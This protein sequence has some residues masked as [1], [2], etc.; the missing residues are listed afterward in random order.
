ML[1]MIRF[2]YRNLNNKSAEISSASHQY[3]LPERSRNKFGMTSGAFAFTLAEVLITL[4]IIGVVAALTIP[5]LMKNWQDLQYKTA[6]KRAYSLGLQALTNA[7]RDDL[8]IPVTGEDDSNCKLNFLAFMSQFKVG[9]KCIES[10]NEKC[11]NSVGDKYNNHPGSSYY[12]FIDASGNSWSM[13][14][15]KSSAFFVDTNNLAAPNRW[16]KDRFA[17]SGANAMGKN[18]DI[19]GGIPEKLI[20]VVDGWER[21]DNYGTSWLYK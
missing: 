10:N 2:T 1:S 3:S 9:R 16:G 14:W 7:N 12:A 5:S 15:D 18:I 17:F 21:A 20:P 13:Y 4:G 11:W 8:L 6:Y 19:V